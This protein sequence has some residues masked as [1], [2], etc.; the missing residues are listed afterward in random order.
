MANVRQAGAFVVIGR[1]QAEATPG[2]NQFDQQVKNGLQRTQNTAIKSQKAMS[3]AATQL[4]FAAEDA[5]AVYGTTGLSGVLRAV[6]NNAVAA[7]AQ[8]SHLAGKFAGLI[9]IAVTAGLILAHFGIKA[10]QAGKDVGKMVKE[11]DFAEKNFK[12]F[13]K[14]QR[15]MT[16]IGD[17]DDAGQ[18]KD[19]AKTMKRDAEELRK[20]ADFTENQLS[21]LVAELGGTGNVNQGFKFDSI[22]DTDKDRIREMSE[23]ILLARQEAARLEQALGQVNAKAAELERAENLE[24]LKDDLKDIQNEAF[25]FA[26]SVRDGIISTINEADDE[27]A[28]KIK[29]DSKVKEVEELADKIREIRREFR[30]AGGENEAASLVELNRLEKTKEGLEAQLKLQELLNRKKELEQQLAIRVPSTVGFLEQGSLAALRRTS[31]ITSSAANNAQTTELINIKT[32]IQRILTILQGL[33][34]DIEDI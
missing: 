2:M 11:M 8:V 12:A 21:R 15:D 3:G 29:F 28:D 27:L 22:N 13:L 19:R 31:E 9:P 1:V 6:G 17:L 18:A 25:N 26:Q 10:L 14:F 5:V 33:E 16:E 23:E 4:A 30:D 32:E 34:D 24:D 20:Q 7:S